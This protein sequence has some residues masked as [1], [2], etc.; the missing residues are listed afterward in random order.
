MARP[1]AGRH[2]HTVSLNRG[3]ASNPSAPEEITAWHVA[4]TDGADHVMQQGLGGVI[5]VVWQ[6]LRDT[7]G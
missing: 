4:S 6:E 5:H 3:A 2:R 7:A 1:M